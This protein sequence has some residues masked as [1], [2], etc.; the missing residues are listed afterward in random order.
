MRND[1]LN[2]SVFNLGNDE[3]YLEWRKEKLAGYPGS[4]QE[5]IVEIEDPYNLTDQE[6]ATILE[7]CAKTNMVVYAVKNPDIVTRNPL[8]DL[9][10]QLGV[11]E[12]DNNLGAGSGGLSKLSPGGSAHG[13][14]A[15]FIPYRQA[16][17]G[18]HTDGYY[19]P[20][21]R[22]I[23]TLALYCE[24]SA[25]EG[26]ENELLDHEIA[27]I[28]LRDENP[29]F[30]RTFMDPE[31]MTI[32]ARLENGNIARPDRVG[33]VFSVDPDSGHL[34][35]RYTAR[36]ISIRWKQSQAVQEALAA[37]T[38]I[39]K[40][41]SPF[42]FRGRLETGLGLISSNVLHTR[43]AFNDLDDGPKRV[44]YRLRCFDRVGY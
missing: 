6:R 3:A 17:I 9:L 16:A 33:P 2:V 34:H 5:L 1:R 30:I 15:N 23:K 10:R 7:L 21:D 40:G 4:L 13:P 27:Y 44:L 36:T 29:E 38:R 12:I 24:R 28:R 19:N 8:P 43:E 22:Q 20:N 37:L 42:I 35:M 32:P 11:T 31:V 39:M 14:F 25:H 41:P 26:G 18:W